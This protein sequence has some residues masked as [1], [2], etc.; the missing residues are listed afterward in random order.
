[1]PSPPQSMVN[2]GTPSRSSVAIAEP[3]STALA[4]PTPWK[5]STHSTSVPP[6]P[7]VIVG[8]PQ[9]GEGQTH[10]V[11]AALATQFQQRAPQ[12]REVLFAPGGGGNAQASAIEVDQPTVAIPVEQDVVGIEVRMV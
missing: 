4:L 9:M 3:S 2:H 10:V 8:A 6:R 7:G 11:R 1:R 12:A 5:R